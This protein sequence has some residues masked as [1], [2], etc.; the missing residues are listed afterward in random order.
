[1]KQWVTG[2]CTLLL[3]FH[4]KLKLKMIQYEGGK[5]NYTSFKINLLEFTLL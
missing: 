3:R 1:M 2:C 4:T 5:T